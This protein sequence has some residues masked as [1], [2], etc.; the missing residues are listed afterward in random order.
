VLCCRHGL[1]ALRPQFSYPFV[2]AGAYVAGDWYSAADISTLP[3]VL[4]SANA[5]GEVP[6]EVD[7]RRDSAASCPA[8]FNEQAGCSTHVRVKQAGGLLC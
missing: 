8:F 5:L 2:P 4:T 6:W 7:R 3:Y 1:P